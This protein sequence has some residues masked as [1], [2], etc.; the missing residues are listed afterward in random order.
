MF[1]FIVAN[2]EKLN[3]EQNARYKSLYCGLCR[4]LGED[5]AKINKMTLT[6]D[7]VLLIAVLSA[8]YSKTYE[9]EEG[10]CILHPFSNKTFLVNSFTD[11]AA[12]MNIA[13]A[14][15]K[16]LDD[17][18]DD[19]SG[20]AFLKMQMFKKE[21]ERIFKKYPEKCKN[22][23]DCLERL[24]E[25]ERQNTLNPDIPADIFGELMGEIFKVTADETGQKLFDFGKALGRFI[26][27]LDAVAD[28]KDD[29]KKERY[30]PLIRISFETSGSILE[31]LM[32]DC[33]EKFNALEVTQDKDII[34]NILF[35]GVWTKYEEMLKRRK[36]K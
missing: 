24:T 12:D 31:M 9:K 27:V 10:K 32:A 4:K 28:V 34:E 8:V 16:Y 19:K 3:S 2:P 25:V 23:E 30:N 26:Y 20:S 22:I 21:T 29:I 13:L 36:D 17:F 5:R 33:V 15:Y 6:Y 18:K 7:L 14:Y 11:Y 35:S 1:G